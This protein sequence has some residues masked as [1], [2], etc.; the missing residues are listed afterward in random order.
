MQQVTPK[1]IARKGKGGGAV[2]PKKDSGNGRMSPPEAD[3][4]F[5]TTLGLG[6]RNSLKVGP[7]NVT[8]TMVNGRIV[9]SASP[10]GTISDSRNDNS[11]LGT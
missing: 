4:P 3:N 5:G 2:G 10:L 1:T 7:H 8:M 9:E 11:A 6:L